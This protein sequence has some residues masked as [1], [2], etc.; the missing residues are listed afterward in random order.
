MGKFWA[1]F[2]SLELPNM[3]KICTCVMNK[4]TYLLRVEFEEV[5]FVFDVIISLEI[6]Y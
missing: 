2:I 1:N 6:N 4:W 3:T 5:T